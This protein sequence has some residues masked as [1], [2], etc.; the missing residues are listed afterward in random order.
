MNHFPRKGSGVI[1][2]P[3][4]WGSSNAHIWMFPK[5]GVPQMDGLFHGKPNEQMDDLGGF[6]IIFGST[7]IMVVL[8]DFSYNNACI[9]WVGIKSHDPWGWMM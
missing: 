6:P 8:K 5:I 3:I 2:L 9:V 4:F 1:K 7:P